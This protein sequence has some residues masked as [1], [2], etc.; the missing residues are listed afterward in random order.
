MIDD[1]NMPLQ[2]TEK[3]S[4]DT[5]ASTKASMVQN[6][7]QETIMPLD[8][9]IR[10][11]KLVIIHVHELNYPMLKIGWVQ[12]I[13][14]VQLSRTENHPKAKS[15]GST[16]VFF[17]YESQ[18]TKFQSSTSSIPVPLISYRPCTN[19]HCQ[20]C[21]PPPHPTIACNIPCNARE[22]VDVSTLEHAV[23]PGDCSNVGQF[24]S[25]VLPE[26]QNCANNN[27]RMVYFPV[28]PT[29]GPPMPSVL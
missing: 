27:R 7:Y 4:F 2:I 23:S 11:H 12:H 25:F 16:E 24:L 19:P 29:N 6:R 17:N 1:T 8:D 13:G 5:T 14:R 9:L 15:R 3:P 18:K 20:F 10:F 21:P 22:S 28:P 26:A